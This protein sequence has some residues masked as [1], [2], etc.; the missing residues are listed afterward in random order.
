MKK[1][2]RSGSIILKGLKGGLIATAISLILILIFAF[3]IK[4]IGI[5]DN[6]ISPINQV[7]KTISILIGIIFA[8]KDKQ[9]K[10]LICGV[11]T[12]LIY[13]IIAFVV[14]SILNG[15]FAF[16]KSLFNDILF[17]AIAGA[18]C[19]ILIVNLKHKRA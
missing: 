16:D 11:V 19:G 8:L 15:C 6:L 10:G 9:E 17:G 14:F 1:E 2:N 5:S 3:I 18:I 4:I 13:T 12:G 7:I